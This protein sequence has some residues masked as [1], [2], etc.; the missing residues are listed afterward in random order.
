MFSWYFF[1]KNAKSCWILVVLPRYSLSFHSLF[2]FFIWGSSCSNWIYQN[3]VTLGNK[4][5]SNCKPPNRN[6]SFSAYCS[7]MSLSLFTPILPKLDARHNIS[8]GKKWKWKLELSTAYLQ[9]PSQCHIG[10]KWKLFFFYFWLL[11]FVLLHQF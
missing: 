7:G 1:S 9:F 4:T 8:W 10:I 5:E 11:M 2:F 3:N 6:I